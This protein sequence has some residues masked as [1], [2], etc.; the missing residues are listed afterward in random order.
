VTRDQ[1]QPAL[2]QQLCV[3]THSDE[4]EEAHLGR[5]ALEHRG[6]AHAREQPDVG[7]PLVEQRVEQRGGLAEDLTSHQQGTRGDRVEQRHRGVR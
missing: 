1:A 5:R 3:G 7:Q 2:R 6:Q 4:A